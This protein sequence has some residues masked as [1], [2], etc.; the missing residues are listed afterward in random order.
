VP[1]M[2]I[3]FSDILSHVGTWVYWHHIS[4]Y[5]SNVLVLLKGWCPRQLSCWPTLG[6]ALI[7]Y[8]GKQACNP[9]RVMDKKYIVFLT[10]LF[11]CVP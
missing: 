2:Q 11:H 8:S 9:F 3:I 4:D 10:E 1:K 5:S 6:P 7:L